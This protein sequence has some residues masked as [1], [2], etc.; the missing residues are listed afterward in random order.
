MLG[1]GADLKT[2]QFNR[3]TNLAKESGLGGKV[4]GKM[5]TAAKKN[6]SSAKSTLTK[7]QNKFNKA[8]KA[9]KGK[10]FVSTKNGKA[11]NKSINAAKTAVSS[12]DKQIGKATGNI[13]KRAIDKHG[14]KKV[15]RMVARKLGFKG[16][17]KFMAKLGLGGVMQFAPGVGM[18]ASAVLL[19]SDIALVYSIIKELAD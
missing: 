10:N 1:K 8:S 12:A 6:L 9:Y 19:A 18:A 14:S 7:A 13:L 11:L 16:A 3:L 2:G 15:V 17:V 5:D 4:A